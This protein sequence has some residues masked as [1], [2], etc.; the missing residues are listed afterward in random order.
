MQYIEGPAQ[1]LDGVY[2]RIR[3]RR[4]HH[5]VIEFYE[6]PVSARQFEGWSM[7]YAPAQMADFLRLSKVSRKAIDG[8]DGGSQAIDAGRLLADFWVLHWHGM[9][10]ERPG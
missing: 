7:A 8:A 2:A 4:R 9:P 5:G 10:G 1:A 6:G 3:A